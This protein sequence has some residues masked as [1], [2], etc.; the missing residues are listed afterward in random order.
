MT[1]LRPEEAKPRK[2]ISNA[3]LQNL[4][5]TIACSSVLTGM[6]SVNVFSVLQTSDSYRFL[7]LVSSELYVS[8]IK[9][10]Y[11]L[12]EPVQCSTTS[13]F[14][15]PPESEGRLQISFPEHWHT[16]SQESC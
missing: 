9:S 11:R 10:Y 7:M 6:F 3:G 2:S 12:P 14:S 13:G 4:F 1:A 16:L 8:I 5:K 15:L